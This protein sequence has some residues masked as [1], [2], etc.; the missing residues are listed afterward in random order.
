MK[1]FS[2]AVISAGLAAA[3]VPAS[4]LLGACGASQPAS[5]S[6]AETEKAPETA[7]SVA[8]P[9][10]PQ[11]EVA[12]EPLDESIWV[13]T[14]SDSVPVATENANGSTLVNLSRTYTLDE[15]GNSITTHNQSSTDY[16]TSDTSFEFDANGYVTSYTSTN[17]TGESR[18][19]SY[20][21]EFDA[22]G[23]VT[24]RTHVNESEQTF[25]YDENGVV[26]ASDET[27]FTD[28]STTHC[29]Y[30]ELGLQTQLTYTDSDPAFSYSQ[31]YAYTFDAQG[32]PASYTS[33]LTSSDGE[34]VEHHTL[35]YDANGNLAIDA[36]EIYTITYEWTRVEHPSAAVQARYCIIP[37]LGAL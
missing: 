17:A 36:S 19:G 13:L 11:T 8:Q 31:T 21:Y 23:R 14:K 28:G 25:T 2:Q 30:N 4:A 29:D 27:S 18:A 1:R 37:G 24:K 10:T 6:Q 9:E 35:E 5:S 26:R 20:L 16:F 3:L 7:Q 32:R 34:T 15:H 33:T 12:P 22:N